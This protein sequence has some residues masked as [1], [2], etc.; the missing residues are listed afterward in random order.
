MMLTPWE[1]VGPVTRGAGTRQCLRDNN[2]IYRILVPPAGMT[3]QHRWDETLCTI[4]A[5]S[6]TADVDGFLVRKPRYPLPDK[7]TGVRVDPLS[8]VS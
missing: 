1:I 2:Y 6:S 5:P 7:A 3:P 4:H 8:A